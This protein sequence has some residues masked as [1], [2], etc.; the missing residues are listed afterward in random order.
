MCIAK[1]IQGIA[2]HYTEKIQ[3]LEE[4]LMTVDYWAVEID[5]VHQSIDEFS[6]GKYS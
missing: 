5:R 6:V 2:F 3:R 4:R 1:Y